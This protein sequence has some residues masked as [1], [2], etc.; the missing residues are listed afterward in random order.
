[1][2][3]KL[4]RICGPH[5]IAGYLN[6]TTEKS[7]PATRTSL[8][9]YIYLGSKFGFRIPSSLPSLVLAIWGPTNVVLKAPKQQPSA[10]VQQFRE[11]RY[12]VSLRSEWEKMVVS[13]ADP[14]L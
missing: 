2:E 13:T 6:L 7:V 5:A 3:L 1:M 11:D 10:C 12:L 8:L 4:P 9:Q 14:C